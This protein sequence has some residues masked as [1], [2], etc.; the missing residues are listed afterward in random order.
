M[1]EY[2][3]SSYVR[4]ILHNFFP[5]VR[6]DTTIPFWWYQHWY[7]NPK[8][9]GISARVWH[10]YLHW[11]TEVVPGKL[12]NQETLEGPVLAKSSKPR[13][14]CCNL[15]HNSPPVETDSGDFSTSVCRALLCKE[16]ETMSLEQRITASPQ[17]RPK[18]FRLHNPEGDGNDSLYW[19]RELLSPEIF[20]ICRS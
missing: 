16:K 19:E 11:N 17:D 12:L 20:A 10:T 15:A 18:S 6:L 2:G 1:W 3:Q 7:Y 14:M 13:G 8:I 9:G 5:Q 4:A